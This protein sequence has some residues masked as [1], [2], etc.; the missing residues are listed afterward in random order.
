MVCYNNSMKPT[1]TSFDEI[2]E[3]E[4][5]A[6]LRTGRRNSAFRTMKDRD[7]GS[8]RLSNGALVEWHVPPPENLDGLPDFFLFPKDIPVGSVAIDGKLYNLEE[9]RKWLRWA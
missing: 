3:A 6:E 9:L 4:K 1:I 8:Y 7:L 5:T 2:M